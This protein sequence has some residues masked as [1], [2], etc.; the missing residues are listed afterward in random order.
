M[1]GDKDPKNR[2]SEGA[3][4]GSKGQVINPDNQ[5]LFTP[6]LNCFT[7]PSNMDYQEGPPE[8]PKN[9][10]KRKGTDHSTESSDDEV[11]LAREDP[12]AGGKLVC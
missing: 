12:I 9:L 4:T 5:D 8:D 1:K 7:D 6:D 11:P 3:K 2:W 10:K